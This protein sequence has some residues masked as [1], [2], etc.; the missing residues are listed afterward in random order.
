MN[1]LKNGD[2]KQRMDS[3][4]EA[5]IKENVDSAMQSMDSAITEISFVMEAMSD[6]D[7]SRRISATL[8]GE[9]HAL[10]ERTNQSLASV[11]QAVSEIVEV[12]VQQQADTSQPN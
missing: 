7:F 4:V 11:D 1:A 6:G 12:S 2:F 3:N 10:K 8:N 9:L 5:S